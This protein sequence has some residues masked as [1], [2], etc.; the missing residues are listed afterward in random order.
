MV[1]MHTCTP[2]HTHVQQNIAIIQ[3]VSFTDAHQYFAEL[4]KCNS[5][6][7]YIIDKRHAEQIMVKM[8][9][10]YSGGLIWKTLMRPVIC[11]A[12]GCPA[13]GYLCWRRLKSEKAVAMTLFHD[14]VL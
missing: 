12:S 9:K 1:G 3:S 14:K 10:D 13:H 5:L 11:F 6:L 7:T 2:P 8:R 4:V